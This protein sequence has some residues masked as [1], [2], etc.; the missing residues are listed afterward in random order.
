METNFSG[1]RKNISMKNVNLE[2]DKDVVKIY[3]L[4]EC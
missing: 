1:I 3:K 4:A 2:I